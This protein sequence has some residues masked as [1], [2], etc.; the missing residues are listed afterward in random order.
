MEKNR[1]KLYDGK[2]F[3]FH[4]SSYGLEN[5]YLDYQTLGFIVGDA[6]LN[7]TVRGETMTEWEMV[8]GEFGEYDMV[9]QDYIIS[10]RGYEILSE[11]T[12]EIVFYNENLDMYIWS[13]T[14]YGTA[15]SHVLTD[16]ELI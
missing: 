9:F 3:G 6:I 7:N 2:T 11:L 16:V 13:I 1:I 8:N 14:H 12:D 4:V 15:W 5:G 10:E